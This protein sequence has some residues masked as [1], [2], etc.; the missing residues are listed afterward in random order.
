M[1]GFKA[2]VQVEVD[3]LTAIRQKAAL[4]IVDEA[5]REIAF[6]VLRRAIV[7][8]EQQVYTRPNVQ[9]T[10]EKMGIVPEPTGALMNSGYVRTF[11]GKLP[12]GCKDEAEAT[13]SAKAKN[14]DVV[15]GQA[16][17]GPARL[18]QAQVLFAVEYGL[19]VEMGTI[20]GMVA[21]PYLGR[22]AEEVQEFA[23]RFVRA[24]LKEAGFTS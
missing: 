11:T 10:A 17:P 19:Y 1:A 18:G 21:R 24:K 22:A 20:L 2:G 4:E 15:F 23:G 8:L 7:Y 9:V 13:S 12:P 14:P 5:A 3:K 16:P 6:E